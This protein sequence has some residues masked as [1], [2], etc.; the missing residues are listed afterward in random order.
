MGIDA[1]IGASHGAASKSQWN[2]SWPNP[3]KCT[4]MPLAR[5]ASPE[6]ICRAVRFILESPAVTGQMIAVDA[7]QHMGVTAVGVAPDDGKA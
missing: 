5:K 1:D 3:A 2:W 7:G 6:D 4:A